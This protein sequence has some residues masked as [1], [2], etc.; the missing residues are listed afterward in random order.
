VDP[1]GSTDQ[2]A[3]RTASPHPVP[4]AIKSRLS[5]RD[6]FALPAA[7]IVLIVMTVVGLAYLSVAL[8]EV[9]LA[10]KEENNAKAFALAEAGRHRALYKLITTDDWST[11][12]SQLY[13]G[14]ALGDGTYD[15]VLTD[16]SASS[17]T[18]E[19][20]GTVGSM[21]RMVVQDCQK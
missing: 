12:P 4:A 20:T 18:I 15:V 7:I 9:D 17:V 8:F 3:S 11:L 5:R 10:V 16:R 1:H 6:G 21:A 13:S 14:V 2:D 19:S